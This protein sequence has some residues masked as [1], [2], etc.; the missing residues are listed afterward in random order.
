[1]YTNKQ[2]NKIIAKQHNEKYQKCRIDSTEQIFLKIRDIIDNLSMDDDYL[3]H[4]CNHHHHHHHPDDYNGPKQLQKSYQWFIRLIG[5]M[6]I[7]KNENIFFVFSNER[8]WNYTQK[9]ISF[10]PKKNSNKLPSNKSVDHH[11]LIISIVCA[12][13]YRS[14]R[15]IINRIDHIYPWCCCMI[16]QCELHTY[17][18]TFN[19]GI[20]P[21]F[22]KVFFSKHITTTNKKK[23]K[24]NQTF[25]PY[26]DT[27]T[28]R[29]KITK[30]IGHTQTN[31]QTIELW[32][33]N[34]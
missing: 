11:Q 20:R 22:F 34:K 24:Q 32:M 7:I 9:N 23:R 10:F 25:F 15:S 26:I 21:L 30:L 6:K 2:A 31:K 14:N 28:E 5:P 3:Y 19:P 33:T 27:R 8:K 12:C 18:M 13:M 16:C 29:K 17:T 4:D 1:M